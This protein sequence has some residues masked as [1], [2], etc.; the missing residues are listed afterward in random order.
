MG[1]W[2]VW[3]GCHCHPHNGRQGEERRREKVE[4]K[5]AFLHQPLA[6]TTLFKVSKSR[7][8]KTK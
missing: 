7:E 1:S 6:V 8:F 3:K 5:E 4:P 2:N